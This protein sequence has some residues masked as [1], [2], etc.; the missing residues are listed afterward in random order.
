MHDVIGQFGGLKV[1]DVLDT[2]EI[3][4]LVSVVYRVY[5]SPI[6]PMVSLFIRKGQRQD[7]KSSCSVVVVMPSS[8]AVLTVSSLHLVHSLDPA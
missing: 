7:H 5:I 2:K 6:V 8:L 4:L 1:C 3:E